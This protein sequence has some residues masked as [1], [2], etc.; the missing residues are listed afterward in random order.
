MVVGFD[1]GWICGGG[2]Y[3][4]WSGGGGFAMSFFLDFLGLS[5]IVVGLCFV[6]G[7]VVFN[8]GDGFWTR[9]DL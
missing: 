3:G 4:F 7:G 1:L 2:D 6:V 9:V 8:G 5:F